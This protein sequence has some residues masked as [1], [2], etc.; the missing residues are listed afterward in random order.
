MNRILTGSEQIQLERVNQ[1]LKYTNE[2][3]DNHKRGELRLAAIALLIDG[4]P[5]P[6]FN[7]WDMDYKES[8]VIAGALIAAEID[9]VERILQ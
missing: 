1:R 6:W 5:H 4:M 7:R 3:D 2:H 8:L 9:R